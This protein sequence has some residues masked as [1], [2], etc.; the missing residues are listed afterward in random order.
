MLLAENE[1]P[2]RVP[3]TIPYDHND[4]LKRPGGFHRSHGLPG[5]SMWST[6]TVKELFREQ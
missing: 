1:L 3:H 5:W 4:Q 2:M 6:I